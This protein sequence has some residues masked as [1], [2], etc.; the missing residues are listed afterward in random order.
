M[1]PLKRRKLDQADSNLN[2]PFR[3]PLRTDTT[4]TPTQCGTEGNWSQ[5]THIRT[6]QSKG[7]PQTVIDDDTPPDNSPS[8]DTSS[9]P[10]SKTASATATGTDP[11]ALQKEYATLSR[12]LTSLRQSLDTAQQ[13]VKIETSKH[14]TQVEALISKWKS[15]VRE[16]AEDLFDRS[17]D[18]FKH[19]A[20]E[21]AR[22]H[23]RYM[24]FWEEEE[25]NEPTDEQREILEIQNEEARAQAENYGLLETIEPEIEPANV[26]TVP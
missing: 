20:V 3:S 22:Q 19:Q 24:P 14:D 25:R 8:R 26:S 5:I 6:V 18:T 15:V 2:K 12:Q 7:K 17:K 11:I 1:H 9:P 21:S 4:R 23:D 10:P 13:A 16:A